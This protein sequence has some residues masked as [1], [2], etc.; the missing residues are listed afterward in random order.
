MRDLFFCS[1]DRYTV[2]MLSKRPAVGQSST[3]PTSV[4]QSPEKYH[5]KH[6]TKR[7]VWGVIVFV[8]M[9]ILGTGTVLAY[10]SWQALHHVIVQHSGTT[11]NELK[12]DP[13][14]PELAD[15]KR[16]GERRVNILLLG[17][18]DSSHAGSLL[19]DTMLV[20]SIEPKEKTVTMI[21]LPRDLYVPIPNHGNDK[22]N[23][24]HVYGELQKKGEGPNTSKKVVESTLDIP[25]HYYMRVDF[26]GFKKAID[27]LGGVTL[28]VESALYDSEYPCDKDERRACGFTMKAG[29]QV[30]RG[31]MA[32]KYVRC[33]K[34][35]CGNDFGRAARQ[36]QVLMAMREKA[37]SASTLSNPAKI[38]GLIDTV[39]SHVTTD[40]SLDELQNLATIM[41]EV[42]KDKTVTKVIDGETEGLVYSTMIQGASVVVP[43]LGV[44]NFSGIR[45]FTHNLL[46][47]RYITREAAKV[48]IHN[49]SGKPELTASVKERLALYHYQVVSVD[50]AATQPTTKLKN[51]A[52]ED[53]RFTRT[54]LGQ[55][56]HTSAVSEDRPSNTE[57]DLELWIG[58]DVQKAWLQ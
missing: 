27:T 19:T 17:I 16:E 43:K 40:M 11:T 28:N 31:D 34:G 9:L 32:L 30:V 20:A 25:I 12:N 39:G 5:Q 14:D 50:S 36:Q 26:S 58:S 13:P 33:R 56:F 38:A 24:A 53:K 7:I 41:K 35:N 47:D 2:L 48:V 57:A 1:I 46:T 51:Y 18:G 45:D 29:S 23:S 55:R 4:G 42:P 54:Y 10:K 44:G 6:R 37:L 49:A 22:I 3:K 8:L 15:L 21:S 52:K